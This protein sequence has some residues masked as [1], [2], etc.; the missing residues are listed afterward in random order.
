[1]LLMNM[2]CKQYIQQKRQTNIRVIFAGEER[3]REVPG[4]QKD[5][6]FRPTPTDKAVVPHD[7]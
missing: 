5:T 3:D 4:A 1:M 2:K 6:V 7:F